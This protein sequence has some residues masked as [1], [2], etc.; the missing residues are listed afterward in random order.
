MADIGARQVTAGATAVITV[1]GPTARRVR[2]DIPAAAVEEGI[3]VAEDT[4]NPV[5]LERL[6]D[7]LL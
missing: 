7:E 4:G 2:A 6:F 1:A 5:D 3:R